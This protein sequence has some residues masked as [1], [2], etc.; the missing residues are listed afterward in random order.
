M[1]A[2]ALHNFFPSFKELFQMTVAVILVFSNHLSD[3]LFLFVSHFRDLS[4]FVCPGFAPGLFVL[5]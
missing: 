1:I 4:D 3:Y 2:A 5:F